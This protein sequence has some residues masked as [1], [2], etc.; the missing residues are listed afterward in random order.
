MAVE[1]KVNEEW[2]IS[3]ERAPVGSIIMFAGSSAPSGWLI[4]NGA[5]I[6]RETYSKLFGV[7]DTIYGSESQHTFNIPDLRGI[8]STGVGSQDINGRTKTGPSLGEV[9]EDQFQNITGGTHNTYAATSRSDIT[10]AFTGSTMSGGASASSPSY[11]T[12]ATKAKM[13]F[14]ASNSTAE[15]GARTGAYTHGPEIGLNFIIKY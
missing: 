6:S 3:A 15:D 1:V 10:G 7:I 2:K 11:S 12:S 8:S 13:V 4:C 5:S 9:R 14:D